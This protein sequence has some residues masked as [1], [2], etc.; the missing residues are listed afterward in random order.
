MRKGAELEVGGGSFW[1]SGVK[2]ISRVKS[3]RILVFLFGFKVNGS[4]LTDPKS[5]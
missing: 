3:E 1:Y 5:S 4:H 2:I